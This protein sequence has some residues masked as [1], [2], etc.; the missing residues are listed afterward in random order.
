[1]ERLRRS[2]AFI[3]GLRASL[4][5]TGFEPGTVQRV[6]AHLSDRRLLN[7]QKTIDNLVEARTGKRAAG[8]EKLRSELKR[9]G[10]PEELVEQRLASVSPEAEREAMLALLRSRFESKDSRAKGARFLAGRGFVGDQIEGALDEFFGTP[11]F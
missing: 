6:L 1:L 9:K 4:E 3:E 2:D 7:D 10:A 5:A 11:D 8:I